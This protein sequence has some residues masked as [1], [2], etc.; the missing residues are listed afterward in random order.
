MFWSGRA[1]NQ[2]SAP[3]CIAAGKYQFQGGSKT[4]ELA[5]GVR[6]LAISRRASPP[7]SGTHKCDP[8]CMIYG[9]AEYAGGRGKGSASGKSGSNQVGKVTGSDLHRSVDLLMREANHRAKNMLGL[10]QAIAR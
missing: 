10:V 6:A 1:D 2:T 8:L 9:A 4:A 7:A 5:G 3:T